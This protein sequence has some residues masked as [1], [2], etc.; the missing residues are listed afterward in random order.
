LARAIS[1]SEQGTS[2]GLR[3]TSNRFA[4]VIVPV[5][6]GVVVDSIGL[7]DSFYLIGGF[8]IFCCLVVALWVR[9]IPGFKT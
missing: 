5:I 6:M 1:K 4:S 2:I 9:T 3:T 8:L 7:Q